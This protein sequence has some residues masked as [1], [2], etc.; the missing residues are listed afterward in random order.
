MCSAIAAYRALVNPNAMPY[1]TDAENQLPDYFIA[2]DD[3]TP[4]QHVEVQALHNAGLI[5]HF[6]NSQRA[7]RFAFEHFKDIYMDAYDKG[8]KGCTTFHNPE[9]FQGVL[10]KRRFRKYNLCFPTEDGT[11]FEA[12]GNEKVEY[13]G[14]IHTAANLYDA[15]KVLRQI[16]S[17]FKQRDWWR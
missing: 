7:Y 13:D 1:S 11:T 17:Q 9:V 3:I 6:K 4:T 5:L 16:L 14:E 2:A 8:L 15:L 10:V 12:K